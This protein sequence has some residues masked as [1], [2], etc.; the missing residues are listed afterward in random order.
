MPPEVRS[1]RLGEAFAQMGSTATRWEWRA[2]LG[3]DELAAWGAV[4]RE[5]EWTAEQAGCGQDPPRGCSRL[6][7]VHPDYVQVRCG[8]FPPQCPEPTV[9]RWEARELRVDVPT[10]YRRLAQVLGLGSMASPVQGH[11]MIGLLGHSASAGAASTTWFCAAPA[12]IDELAEWF[13]SRGGGDNQAQLIVM[14][15]A[16]AGVVGSRWASRVA[17]YH[18]LGDVVGVRRG[19]AGPELVVLWSSEGPPAPSSGAPH[20]SRDSTDGPS[21]LPFRLYEGGGVRQPPRNL[22]SAKAE[23]LRQSMPERLCLDL[24]GETLRIAVPPDRE[25]R[26]LKARGAVR[27]ARALIW[28]EGAWQGAEALSETS[29]FVGTSP[30]TVRDYAHRFEAALRGLGVGADQLFEHRG[31][32]ESWEMRWAR[33]C[34]LR[35]QVLI[36]RE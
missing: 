32:S 31:A 27:L 11:P 20:A 7:T 17:D 24:V 21:L 35:H 16:Q 28:A 6:L 18:V 13:A 8:Q 33:D 1:A 15:E 23:A 3:D 19:A 26:P 2:R 34:R 4:L 5:T 30:A 36:G 10:L 29:G 25:W 22:D 9:T 14:D 12:D